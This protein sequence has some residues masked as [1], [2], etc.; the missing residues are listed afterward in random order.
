M[1][2]YLLIVVLSF[3]TLSFV[4][5]RPTTKVVAS[6]TLVQDTLVPIRRSNVKKVANTPTTSQYKKS[7][8]IPSTTKAAS[9][10]VS[11][12]I[13]TTRAVAVCKGDGFF[14]GGKPRFVSG[15]FSDT[16]VAVSG[17]DSIL[18]TELSVLDCQSL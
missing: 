13:V 3:S 2:K 15:I 8:A 4:Q 18:I 17:R 16:L 5:L 6:T 10:E 7:T 11:A 1:S 9:A 14:T 12:R